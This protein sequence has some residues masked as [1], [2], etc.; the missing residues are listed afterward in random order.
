MLF[1]TYE[2]LEEDIIFQTKRLATFLGL[3]FTKQEE[4]EG[5]VEI[6]I[7]CVVV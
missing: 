1:M 5:L 6:Y 2:D 3:P 7:D 4:D